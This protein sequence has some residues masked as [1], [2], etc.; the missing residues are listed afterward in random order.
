MANSRSSRLLY[1]CQREELV[2]K[3]IEPIDV[4]IPE[5]AI[6]QEATNLMNEFADCMQGR[7]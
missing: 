3:L 5:S 6:N 2:T 1:R 7:E 4:K